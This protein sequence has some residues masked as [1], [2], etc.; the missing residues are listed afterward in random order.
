MYM[1]TVGKHSSE[2][3]PTTVAAFIGSL[4]ISQE[5]EQNLPETGSGDSHI[6]S[7]SF[8]IYV[9]GGVRVSLKYSGSASC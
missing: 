4:D 7:M 5:P 6:L 3:V 1:K 8:K 9:G 2:D